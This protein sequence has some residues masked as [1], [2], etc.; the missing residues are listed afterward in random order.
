M[1]DIKTDVVVLGAGFGGSLTA[2]LLDRIGLRPVLIDRDRH[3]RFAIGESSTPTADLVLRDLCRRFDLPRL[4]P[5]TSY[6]TW[7]SAYPELMCGVKR[8]FSYF[9][10][11][12]GKSFM[13]LRDHANELLVA[14]SADESHSDTHWLRADVDAF[15]AGEVVAAGIPYFDGTRVTLTATRDGWSV[16]TRKDDQ[17][18]DEFRIQTRFLIDATGANGEVLRA[19]GVPSDRSTLHTNS[20]ALFA[21]FRDLP[22]WKESIA[23]TAFQTDHPFDC[24]QAA[25]HHVI[26]EGWMWQLRFRNGV[27]SAGFVIDMQ[28]S[29]SESIDSKQQSGGDEWLRLLK[30]YPSLNAQF[31]SATLIAPETG[32]QTTSRLQ[33]LAKHMAGPTWA[34]LPHTAGFIDPLHSTGIAHTLIGIERL[35]GIFERHWA[36]STMADALRGY[37]FATRAEFTLIDELVSGC[38]AARSNFR[39]FS[40]FSM[41]YF[42]AAT[43]FERARASSR[44][45]ESTFL[46]ANNASFRN[47]V[48]RLHEKLIAVSRLGPIS[49]ATATAFEREVA[50]DIQPFNH[51]GLCDPGVNNMYRYTAASK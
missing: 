8:G 2:L 22:P 20:R 15:F 13:P 1:K 37:E 3:P 11:Q 49:N 48:R 10:H 32:L 12:P 47:V 40:A 38:Y 25:Q 26:D 33:R 27:T 44:S 41:L 35:I 23:S 42:A 18:V 7:R 4:E 21:H 34:A 45:P 5:L 19:V 36:K 9:R 51:V 14:A 6:G 30:R 28:Q 29:P 43:T 16:A 46:I 39:A 31:A 17:S 50:I 24:D